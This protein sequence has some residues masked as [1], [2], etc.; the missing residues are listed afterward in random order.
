ME[1]ENG[2]EVTLMSLSSDLT[3]NSNDEINFPHKLSLTDTQVSKIR[4][5]FAN[6]SSVNIKFKK[7]SYSQ[8]EL[9]FPFLEI[10]YR[11]QVKK[12]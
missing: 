7:N 12:E 6:G 10:F 5:S 8:K 9:L 1:W 4:E 2:T 3:G 11:V